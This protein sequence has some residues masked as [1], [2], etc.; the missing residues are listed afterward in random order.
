MVDKIQAVG[1]I[2]SLTWFDATGT[3]AG[4]ISYANHRNSLGISTGGNFLYEDG[5][6]LWRKFDLANRKSTIDIGTAVGWTVFYRPGDLGPGP[7]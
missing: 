7:Y 1:T 5:S 6:A 4:T 2:P 3:T